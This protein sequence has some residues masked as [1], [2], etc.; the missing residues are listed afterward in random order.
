VL[1]YILRQLNV[2][3]YLSARSLSQSQRT[4]RVMMDGSYAGGL[5]ERIVDGSKLSAF[6]LTVADMLMLCALLIPATPVIFASRT[7]NSTVQ[8]A[9]S[10]AVT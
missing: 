9:A 1:F 3:F 7:I 6:V 8:S 2:S 4:Q 10:E 5:H